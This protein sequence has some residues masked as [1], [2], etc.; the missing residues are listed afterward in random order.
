MEDQRNAKDPVTRAAN[1][2]K[3]LKNLQVL[4]R[5]PIIAVSQMNRNELD[6]DSII[7]VSHIAQ[8]DRIGQD[9]TV[10]LALRQKDHVLTIDIAKS[11]DSGSGSKLKYAIDFDKGVFQF[12]P[13]EDDA[14]KGGEGCNDL[15]KEYE[16]EYQ[17]DGGS[18]F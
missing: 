9:S 6:D 16:P 15:Q 3:D 1:I 10:V 7:D 13:N 4:K 17:Y 18:P 12:I 14:L 11:R 8:T 2:S 5:I